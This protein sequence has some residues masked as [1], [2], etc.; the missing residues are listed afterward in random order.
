MVFQIQ[1]FECQQW[2]HKKADYCSENAKKKEFQPPLPMQRE[3]FLNYN[4]N[5]SKARTSI[6][7]KNVK[8]NYLSIKEEQ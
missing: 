7:P 4:K 2:G 5:Q 1:Y 6:Q 3:V 8:V